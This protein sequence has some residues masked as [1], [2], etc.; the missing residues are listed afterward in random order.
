MSAYDVIVVGSGSVGNPT[1]CFLA[2]R[3]LKVLVVE[4]RAAGMD[5]SMHAL[6]SEIE[7]FAVE[8]PR[9]WSEAKNLNQP[10]SRG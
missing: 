1:A 8:L 2:Q 9:D 6:L 4:R 5:L 3:G 10:D 7:A